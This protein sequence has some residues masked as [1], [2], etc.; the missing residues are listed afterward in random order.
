MAAACRT[1]RKP[2]PRRNG[3]RRDPPAAA[4]LSAAKAGPMNCAEFDTFILCRLTAT[5]YIVEQIAG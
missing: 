1:A 4:Y 5:V 3:D 2:P